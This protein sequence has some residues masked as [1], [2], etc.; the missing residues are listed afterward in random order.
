MNDFK[1][2]R[3]KARL[4]LSAMANLM[5]ISKSM[6]FKIEEGKRQL[7]YSQ[8]IKLTA[9]QEELAHISTTGKKAETGRVAFTNTGMLAELHKA[10]MERHLKQ[11]AGCKWKLEKL[12]QDMHILE[13]QSALHELIGNLVIPGQTRKRGDELL[14]EIMELNFK[15]KSGALVPEQEM[16]QD[17]IDTH[18][19]YA[20]LHQEKWKEYLEMKID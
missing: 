7:S 18:L 10:K 3:Q 19:A 15:K 13:K 6:A 14:L 16:L 9:I 17:K 5:G 11:A 4:S 20:D 1:K 8:I 2:A 12:Q